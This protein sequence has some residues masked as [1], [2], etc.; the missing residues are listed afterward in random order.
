LAAQG[1]AA[2]SLGDWA[3][4]VGAVVGVLSLIIAIVA[5]LT[6]SA[7]D[8]ADQLN[9]EPELRREIAAGLRGGTAGAFYRDQLAAGLAFL[10]HRMGPPGSARALGVSILLAIVYAWATFA[11]PWGLGAPGVVGGFELLPKAPQ[12]GRA[13]AAAVLIMMPP[14]L[15]RLGTALGRRMGRA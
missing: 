13:I 3:G 12:P 9:D 4:I 11:L 6:P 14:L 10:D 1:G 5:W 7:R 2:L 15:Y 8:V